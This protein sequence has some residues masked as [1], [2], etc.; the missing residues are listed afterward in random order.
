MLIAAGWRAVSPVAFAH[1]DGREIF[2]CSR[3]GRWAMRRPAGPDRLLGRS[4]QDAIEAIRKLKE[5][6]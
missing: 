3:F 5:V 6:V 4:L 2:R 1:P